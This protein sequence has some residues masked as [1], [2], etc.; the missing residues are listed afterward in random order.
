MWPDRLMGVF[1]ER[2]RQVKVKTLAPLARRYAEMSPL[3]ITV[4]GF[5]V[6]LVC[7]GTAAV[8][9][10]WAALALWLLNRTLDGLDGEVAR[11]TGKQSD[12]G[13][14]LDIVCDFVIYA[15]VPFALAWSLKSPLALFAVA[16]LLVTF[17]INAASWL[18]L[19]ALLE[20]RRHQAQSLTSIVFPSGLIE[21]TETV[22]FYTLFLL[23]P[24]WSPY[25]M[26]LMA[27]LIIITI[28]QRLSWA[29]SQLGH[30]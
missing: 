19:S 29:E 7:A 3:Q 18:Y 22:M 10:Y 30:E 24:A 26:F 27:F 16:F 28:F 17:Y 1:D 14:Y 2:L 6:G 8:G 4:V 5:F 13:G 11:L 12:W 25:L 15:L 21:G 23:L 9:N 20:K